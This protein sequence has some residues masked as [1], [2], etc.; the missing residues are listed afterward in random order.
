MTH[1]HYHVVLEH[2]R[3]ITVVDP[4]PFHPHL[5]HCLSLSHTPVPSPPPLIL[6]QATQPSMF[7]DKLQVIIAQVIRVSVVIS[8]DFKGYLSFKAASPIKFS[9]GCFKLKV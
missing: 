8:I 6:S 4:H 2:I 1:S 3:N 9:Y 5:S 7:H